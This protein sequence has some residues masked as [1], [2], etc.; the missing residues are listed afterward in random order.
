ML[1]EDWLQAFKMLLFKKKTTRERNRMAVFCGN[2]I[3]PDNET[4]MENL[5]RYII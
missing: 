2:R 1:A 4:A 5:V 3:S